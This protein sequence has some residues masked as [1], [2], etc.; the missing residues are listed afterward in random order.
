MSQKSPGFFQHLASCMRAQTWNYAISFQS[1]FHVFGKVNKPNKRLV[2][3][4]VVFLIAQTGI[5]E[6]HETGAIR[7]SMPKF[8]WNEI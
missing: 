4:R 5:I 7:G 1:A 8:I 6:R 2:C 3:V